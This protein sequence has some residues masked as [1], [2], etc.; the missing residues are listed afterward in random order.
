MRRVLATTAV[1][2]LLVAACSDDP[3]PQTQPT[4]S[5]TSTSAS[6]EPGPTG[7]QIYAVSIDAPPAA[8]SNRQFSAYY[9]ST[10]S[11]RPGDTVNFAM[12]NQAHTVTFGIAADA[13]NVP[14]LVTDKGEFNPAVFGPCITPTAA[15]KAMLACPANGSPPGSPYS[16]SGY[17]NS[18][19]LVGDPKAPN[20][21]TALT[22]TP[23]I[24]PG[25]YTYL[26]LL[27]AFMRG[28]I[29]VVAEDSARKSSADVVAQGDTE[30]V[31][32]Q[33]AAAGLTAP[34]AQPG[35]VT[36]GW[37]D[38]VVAVLEF[39]PTTVSVA[40]G[41][42]VT[43]KVEGPYEPHTVT[44]SSPFAGPEDPKA[45]MPGG[46]KSGG[47]YSGGFSHSGFI[48]PAPFFPGAE[49]SLTFTKAGS[50]PYVCVI[51]PGMTGSVTVT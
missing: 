49:F 33:T 42:S 1:A 24:A 51:H 40:R 37:G 7:T 18:G 34:A 36:A 44:F 48:G 2:V 6:P 31:A 13:S 12:R 10:L 9:P 38:Q 39:N 32:H 5:A 3:T 22:F 46:V 45:L 19:V 11:V 27:H 41:G 25:T 28:S 20:S 14:P 29:T 23:S 8:G 21:K 30:L 26:C 4:P 17:W 15:S 47:Q 16:G 43:W 35:R 50:Y